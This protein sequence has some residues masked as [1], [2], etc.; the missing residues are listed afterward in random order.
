MKEEKTVKMHRICPFFKIKCKMDE[1][2]FY[3][4]EK[5]K[6]DYWYKCSDKKII[7][8]KETD[9]RVEYDSWTRV[10]IVREFM[11]DEVRWYEL[12]FC[13]ILK[14]KSKQSVKILYRIKY[15]KPQKGSESDYINK[16]KPK[17]SLW[18]VLFKFRE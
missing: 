4:K 1:C 12:G 5:T 6:D 9:Y 10:D 7:K 3:R 13:D 15:S 16:D 2:V 18:S 14:D 17:I 11:Y 8:E